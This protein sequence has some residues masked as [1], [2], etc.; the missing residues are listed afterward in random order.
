M[1]LSPAAALGHTL[2]LHFGDD[3]PARIGLAVSGGGDSR[4]LLEIAALWAP[5]WGVALEAATVDHGLRAGSAAEARAVAA[6]CA[7][8][9]V[10]HRILRWDP[11]TGGNLQAAAREGRFRLLAAWAR[12]RDL[13]AVLTGHTRDDQ[14]ETV[15][16]R[17]AREAGVDGLSGIAPQVRRHGVTFARPLLKT[18]R[19]ALREMLRAEGHDW[20]EDPSNADPAFARTRARHALAALAPL[21]IG[22]E[23]LAG[24]AENMASAREVLDAALCAAV[25]RHVRQDGGDLIL[26]GAVHAL[27]DETRRRLL[28]AGLRWIGGGSYPPRRAALDRFGGAA[29]GGQ[30]PTLAGV[31]ALPHD[32][33]LRLTRDP[34][35]VRAAQAPVGA[36]WDGRWRIEGPPGTVRALGPLGLAQIERTARPD[37]PRAALMARP[38]VWDGDTLLAVAGS[39]GRWSLHLVPDRDDFAANLPSH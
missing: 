37:L 8:L 28:I 16:M 25:D 30:A 20:I 7:T 21:G 33:G 19:A 17:L 23:T 13:G 15:L 9:R 1:C 14:A 34:A 5:A 18:G 10:P 27:P 4:A 36:V 11:P 3:P 35:A 38:A 26:D 31:L 39:P 12:E 22:A 32:D 29:A 6:R 2:V 24:V